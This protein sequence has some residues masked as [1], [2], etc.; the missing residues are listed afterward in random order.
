MKVC[1]SHPFSDASHTLLPSNHEGYIER[2]LNEAFGFT[3][4]AGERHVYLNTPGNTARVL[5]SG[6]NYLYLFVSLLVIFCFIL[7]FTLLNLA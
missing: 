6:K 3:T 5:L 1:V 2:C 7:H 4:F